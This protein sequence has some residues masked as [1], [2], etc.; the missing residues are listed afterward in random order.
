MIQN[1][2]NSSKFPTVSADKKNSAGKFR[3]IFVA[4]V[5]VVFLVGFAGHAVFY[6]RWFPSFL[7]RQWLKTYDPPIK[8]VSLSYRERRSGPGILFEFDGVRIVLEKQGVQQKIDLERLQA[9]LKNN[10]FAREKEWRVALDGVHWM[11]QDLTVDGLQLA[12]RL[13]FLKNDARTITGTVSAGNI[14]FGGYSLEAA[15]ASLAGNE[16]SLAF[17]DFSTRAYGGNIR[18]EILLDVPASVVSYTLNLTIDGMDLKE[19]AAAN[20]AVFSQVE[21]RLNGSGT[22]KGDSADILLLDGN[23]DISHGGKIK[24]SW[25]RP[26]VDYIPQSQQKKQLEDL[27]KADSF[28]PVEKATLQ[29]ESLSA[30]QISSLIVVQSA[31]LNMNLNLAVDI[32]LEQ[33]VSEDFK[34]LL[35]RFIPSSAFTGGGV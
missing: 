10:F 11:V 14:R 5:L 4:L 30:A 26:V 7:L 3:N 35:F 29:L 1:S 17:K 23:L 33:G 19:L 25:L 27:I 15:S 12:L 34:N 9:E 8:L 24:A 22:I 6:S 13:E 31:Q 28:I 18:G 20:S 32:N 2:T 21:G 16:R